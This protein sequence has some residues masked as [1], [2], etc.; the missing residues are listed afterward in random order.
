M[1][2][3]SHSVYGNVPFQYQKNGGA[4]QR[5]THNLGGRSNANNP[6]PNYNNF[7]KSNELLG[8]KG[9]FKSTE[10]L[11]RSGRLPFSDRNGKLHR[12]NPHLFFSGLK[13]SEP[14]C[15]PNPSKTTSK[16]K[17]EISHAA[18][19]VNRKW[20]DFVFRRNTDNKLYRSES[21]RFIQKTSSLQLL[22]PLS[23]GLNKYRS[24][25]FQVSKTS[26]KYL[27]IH[28]CSLN[29]FVDKRC[30]KSDQVA[31]SMFCLW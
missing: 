14:N 8:K 23:A 3:H 28:V 11:N 20:C 17:S 1:A 24:K 7:G 10:V 22:P 15:K 4:S 30:M 21:F 26:C 13:L 19:L 18:N 2:Q 6:N 31:E 16:W 29:L 27:Q 12:S 25:K 5:Y 9:M